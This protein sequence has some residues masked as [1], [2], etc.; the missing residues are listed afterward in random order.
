MEVGV[1]ILVVILG[2]VFGGIGIQFVPECFKKRSDSDIERR[3]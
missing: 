3:I 1:I 2:G